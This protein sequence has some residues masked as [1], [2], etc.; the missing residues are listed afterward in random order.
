MWGCFDAADI[1]EVKAVP[2]GF[3]RL[4][5]QR[6]VLEIVSTRTQWWVLRW[7]KQ[8]IFWEEMQQRLKEKQGSMTTPPADFCS[9]VQ[10]YNWALRKKFLCRTGTLSF[11][12]C[13]FKIRKCNLLVMI[14]KACSYLTAWT[15]CTWITHPMSVSFLVSCCPLCYEHNPLVK[16]EKQMFTKNS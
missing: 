6:S 10:L 1:G 16:A 12:L 11:F 13:V 8:L 14:K 15:A 5:C 2:R 4:F 3:D 7:E 9:P